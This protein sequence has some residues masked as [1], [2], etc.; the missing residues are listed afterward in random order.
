MCVP[1]ARLL[2]FDASVKIG[3]VLRMVKAFAA[4]LNLR[5]VRN[6]EQQQHNRVEILL[7]SR[8]HTLCFKS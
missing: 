5:A 7:P 8:R 3:G 6:V 4:E 2:T 1:R